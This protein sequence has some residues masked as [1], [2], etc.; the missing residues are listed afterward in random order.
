MQLAED[1]P[2]RIRAWRLKGAGLDRFGRD[3]GP[4]CIRFPRYG[5]G[6]LIVRIDAVGICFSDVK[7]VRA[8]GS[9][10]RPR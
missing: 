10:P 6:D 9:H 2:E 5:E 7:L 4:D 8:G 1:L 3:G